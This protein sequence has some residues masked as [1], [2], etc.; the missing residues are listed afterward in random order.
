MKRWLV[1]RRWRIVEDGMENA[2]RLELLSDEEF[3]DFMRGER[4]V[5]ENETYSV[6]E[7]PI[8]ATVNRN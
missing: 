5:K 2:P 4:L 6:Y 8:N 7:L 1:I 3:A